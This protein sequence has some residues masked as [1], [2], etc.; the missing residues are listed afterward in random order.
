MLPGGPHL[1]E[2]FQPGLVQ[3]EDVAS[4]SRRKIRIMKDRKMEGKKEVVGR[5]KKYRNGKGG[6]EELQKYKAEEENCFENDKWERTMDR[7][8]EKHYSIKLKWRRD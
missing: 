2:T 1:W 5:R 7:D 6:K 3:D 8:R 4:R